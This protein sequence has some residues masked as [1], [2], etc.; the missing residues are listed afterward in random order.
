M[1]GL[2]QRMALLHRVIQACGSQAPASLGSCHICKVKATATFRFSRKVQ[3]RKRRRC[4]SAVL[5]SL[6]TS[7]LLTFHRQNSVL[8]LNLPVRRAGKHCSLLAG[9]VSKGDS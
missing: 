1:G 8:C 5:R 4:T 7:H 3:G 6:D 2:D 9:P